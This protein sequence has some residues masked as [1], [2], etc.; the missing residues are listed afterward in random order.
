MQEN[1]KVYSA[2]LIALLTLSAYFLADTVDALIG[3]SLDAAPRFTSPLEAGQPAI[4]PR[5]E[6]SDYSSI[7]ERGL[8][9]DGKGPSTAPASA[10]ITNYTLIG[11]VEGDV[12]AGAVLEDATG[13]A[14][15]RLHQKL[16]D[17]SRI[18]KVLRDRVTLRRA[19][20]STADIQIVDEARIVNIGGKPAAAAPGVRKLSD[21]RFAVDQR[22]VLA[23][24]ENMSQLLTQARALPFVEQGKTVGFRISDIV[25]GSLYEK[26]GL[27]N[28]D[29]IQKI[30]SQDVDD[31]GKF[32]QL[33][34]GLKEERNVS[35]DL[36]RGGQRQSFNYEIR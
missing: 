25:P 15:Y 29:V 24:T 34:Q 1:K 13:Q 6:L 27:Q 18:V 23:S 4:E 11:T 21:G 26:I 20:G 31:P 33:Y 30:N 2:I 17:G 12:F 5:R 7:L 35:I 16:S 9:G 10:E 32:F 36:I 8:F 19:D 14:F 3:R 28:G 22:E